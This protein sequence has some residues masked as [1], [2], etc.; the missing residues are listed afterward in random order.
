MADMNNMHNYSLEAL[1]VP[2]EDWLGAFYRPTDTLCIRV[3]SDKKGSDYFGQK[4]TCIL[5]EFPD[6]IES[7]MTHNQHGRGIFNVVNQGGHDDVSITRITAHYVEMDDVSLEEQLARIQEFPLPPSLIAKTA[8]S[9]HC[10]WL[11]SEGGA[12]VARFR[13]IQKQLVAQF[14]GDAACINES[15]VLRIPGFYHCKGEPILVECVKFNPE[16]RYTQD[17]LTEHLPSIHDDGETTH[18]AN[19]THT[20]PVNCGT[21]KGLVRIGSECPF[22]QHCKKNAKTLCEPDWHAMISN[23]AMFEGGVETIHKL[24]KPHPEYDFGKTQRKIENI[25]KS[26]IKPITCQ[27]IMERSREKDGAEPFRCPNYGKCKSRS[28][29]GLAYFP[30]EVDDI[31]KRLES[32][33]IEG[34]T[35][36]KMVTAK[37][38]INNFLFNV[39]S[40]VA[41]T[42]ISDDIKQR[43]SLKTPH[44]SELIGYYKEV[45]K[46]FF[47]AQKSKRDKGG[48]ELPDW[49]EFT[50][51]GGLKL[52]TGVL[53]DYLRDN[54]HTF[55]ATEQYYY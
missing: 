4:I 8:K 25:C 53:A 37:E 12:E 11:M 55:Y 3:F 26:G 45:S 30:M 32:V 13:H 44:I 46:E 35:V 15:R 23:M 52:M 43:F 9:L 34:T 1:N 49:Y 54:F 38:F 41:T 51:S 16:I 40:A 29:A 42:L 14:N 24:S 36:K 33:K 17:Q 7:L 20:A 10:Y 19:T 39:D 27:T 22:L 28:P 47:T 5:E 48:G 6:K 31:I 21:Q 2:S 18:N 50:K